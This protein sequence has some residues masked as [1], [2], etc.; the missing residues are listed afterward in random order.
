M[1]GSAALV[2]PKIAAGVGCHSLALKQDGTV[3]GWGDNSFGQLGDGTKTNR[4]TP[5]QAKALTN[6]TAIAAG[7]AH[8]L[9]RKSD[10]TVW[11]WGGNGF[12]Q[13]GDGTTTN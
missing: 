8:S 5:V 13:L 9:A 11:A 4:S 12:G 7:D 3:W 6:V 2:S 10:G 1:L